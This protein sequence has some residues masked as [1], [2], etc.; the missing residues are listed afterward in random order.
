LVFPTQDNGSKRKERGGGEKLRDHAV[1]T[2]SSIEVDGQT[3]KKSR[4]EWSRLVC[5]I[6]GKGGQKGQELNRG[7]K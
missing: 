1:N 7:R 2:K 6:Q 4:T 3:A 5:V